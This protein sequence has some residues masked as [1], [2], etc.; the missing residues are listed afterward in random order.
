MLID[1][2]QKVL[3]IFFLLRGS[4]VWS[5]LYDPPNTPPNSSSSPNNNGGTTPR[6]EIRLP[7]LRVND[8]PVPE[9]V[10]GVHPYHRLGGRASSP[11]GTSPPLFYP[12]LF[13][14]R[15]LHPRYF[16]PYYVDDNSTASEDS[17]Q[18]DNRGGGS[19]SQGERPSVD[20]FDRIEREFFFMRG[21]F[22][23]F[24]LMIKMITS[25]H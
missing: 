23:R 11:R 25:F 15:L 3:T 10:P 21:E 17:S 12:P 2:F 22:M 7:V 14:P 9:D 18:Q 5:S 6:T 24:T 19:S 8:G 20:R 1:Y 4:S 13:R 16:S